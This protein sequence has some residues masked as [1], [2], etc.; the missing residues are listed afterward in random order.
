[1]TRKKDV[2]NYAPVTHPE[3]ACLALI[4]KSL[5]STPARQAVMTRALDYGTTVDEIVLGENLI[6]EEIYYGLVAQTLGLAFSSTPLQVIEPLHAADAWRLRIIRLDPDYHAKEWLAAPKGHRLEH[7]LTQE[8]ASNEGFSNLMITTPCALFDSIM[9][10]KV[11]TST[12]Y[13][14]RFL[15][16]KNPDFSCYTLCHMTAKRVAPLILLSVLAL[17]MAFLDIS[18][19]PI[20]TLFLGPVLLA[21]LGVLATTPHAQTESEPL[22][23]DKHLPTYSILVPLYREANLIPQLLHNFS[24]LDYPPARYEVLFLIEEDDRETHAALNANQLPYG[25]YTILVPKGQP[26]TKP[27][28]LNIGLAFATGTLI[29]VYDAEDRPEPQQ[30][31]KAAQQ[32]S[33]GGA[34]TVCLQASLVID[35]LNHGRL[36]HLFALEYAGLFDVIL[37]RLAHKQWPI[38]LG[39]SSNH[40]RKKA[41]SQAL[42]WDPWN[43]TEDADLGLRLKRLG[44]HVA[45]LSSDTYE[46]APDTLRDWFM[47][48]RRWIKGWMMTAAVHLKNPKQVI[49]EIGLQ[50]FLLIAFQSAGLVAAMLFWP[51]TLC[52][53]PYVLLTRTPSLIEIITMLGL[54]LCS[55][56]VI[57]WPLIKGSQIRKHPLPL[58]LLLGLPVYFLLITIAAWAGIWD[59]VRTPHHWNK[60]P[61]K[62]H[63]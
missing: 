25:F 32:F 35:N 16:E 55:L 39:G 62:P 33:C 63:S 49:A 29:V 2:K 51:L 45:H 48:R 27:R 56:P 10:S 59:Y 44:Y 58:W 15:H 20:V 52:D 53:L 43:V 3:P 5:L 37:P 50:N 26:R 46:D 17:C 41:L 54:L 34:N 18:L 8:L 23:S 60:T 4:P 42:G 6:S 36:P 30:L 61:H 47:Q 14:A 19:S 28:A 11:A 7:L 1:M 31:R 24:N 22:L 9:R 13:F 57:L 12:Q 40:F 38:A 21:R